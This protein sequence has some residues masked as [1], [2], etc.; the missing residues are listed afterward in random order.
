MKANNNGFVI[1]I[2]GANTE[3][4]LNSDIRL[5]EKH[6]IPQNDRRDT[7][8][9][10]SLNHTCRLLA[11]GQ[12][13]IPILPIAQDERGDRIVKAIKVAAEKG[14]IKPPDV[15]RINGGHAA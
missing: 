13:V 7:V 11:M 2:G 3:L 10:S 1:T 6:V 9:G 8:G 14:G 4:I 12:P 15:R 5:D